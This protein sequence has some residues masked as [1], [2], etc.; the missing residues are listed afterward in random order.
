MPDTHQNFAAYSGGLRLV[1]VRVPEPPTSRE[2]L[3]PAE[4]TVAECIVRG[5]SNAEIARTR[6]TSAR[7]VANQVAALFERTGVQSR[8]ELVRRLLGGEL[9][10]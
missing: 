3:R 7:T 8:A 6:G 4:R 9:S 1:V 2:A 5:L 10:S